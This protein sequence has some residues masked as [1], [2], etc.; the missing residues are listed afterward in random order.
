MI[1]QDLINDMFAKDACIIYDRDVKN[2]NKGRELVSQGSVYEGRC[3]FQDGEDMLRRLVQLGIEGDGFLYLD[4]VKDVSINDVAEITTD[5]GTITG[6]VVGKN[7][8]SSYVII[9]KRS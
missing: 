3:N 9:K 1:D 8:L 6:T 5:Y 2:T 7:N 4:T